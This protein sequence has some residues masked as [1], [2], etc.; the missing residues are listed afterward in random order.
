[1]PEGVRYFSVN[2]N[3]GSIPTKNVESFLKEHPDAVEHGKF[4]LPDKSEGYIPFDNVNDF[5][6]EYPNARADKDTYNNYNG[7]IQGKRAQQE[8]YSGV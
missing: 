4:V 6:S 3:I 2:G 8:I 1:M 5:L 7:W